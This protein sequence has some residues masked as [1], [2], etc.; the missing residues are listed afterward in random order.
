MKPT[1]IFKSTMLVI[2]LGLTIGSL[3]AYAFGTADDV[4]Q[5][6]Y[7]QAFETLDA[8]KSG[9]L[10]KSE[11]K[12]E[13]Y[14]A[15]RFAAADKNHDGSLDQQE[16]TD[17]RTQ[18]EKKYAKRVGSDSLIT[19]KIKGKLLKD[20]GLKSLKVSVET[21]EG[22]VMLSGFVTTEDQIKQAVQIASETEGVK[23][24]KNSIILKMD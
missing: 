8:D 22:I 3:Q 9:T 19:S 7:T 21:H 20:E 13:K 10:S 24:V 17:H 15:K 1:T 14:F 2:A 6:T 18:A 12:N 16:Y 23:S 5:T 4:D 11:V